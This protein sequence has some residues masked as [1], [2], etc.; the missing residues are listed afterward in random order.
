MTGQIGSAV[1]T[2]DSLVLYQICMKVIPHNLNPIGA[3][4]TFYATALVLTLVASRFVPV[5]SPGWSLSDFSWAVV[6]VG[7]AIVG[8]EMGYLLM[9]RS[10]WHLSAA[11]LV[12]TGAAVVLLLPIGL[13]AFRQPWSARYLVGIVLCLYGIYLLAPQ[14]P[15]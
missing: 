13:L 6:I 11:P 7:V 12:V 5:D 9:Y 2:I 15:S 3:L 4:I 10:G 8:I 1:I 14:E